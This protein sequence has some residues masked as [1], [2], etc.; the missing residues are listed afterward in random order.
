MADQEDQLSDE[1]KVKKVLA[2]G[3]E[4]SRWG[5]GEEGGGGGSGGGFFSPSR[6]QGRKKIKQADVE[7]ARAVSP[8]LLAWK[9]VSFLLPEACFTRR[10]LHSLYGPMAENRLQAPGWG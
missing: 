9:E 6:G 3:G 2:A 4:G 8:T 5:R 10:P 1:E 7:Q